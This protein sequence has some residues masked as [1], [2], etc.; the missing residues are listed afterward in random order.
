MF[1]KTWHFKT[2]YGKCKDKEKTTKNLHD[3]EA[4]GRGVPD[5]RQRQRQRPRQRQR[6]RPRG[7]GEIENETV[8]VKG[9]G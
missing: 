6:Q 3:V 7:K 8:R 2:R 4:D 9:Q 5:Q 1:S